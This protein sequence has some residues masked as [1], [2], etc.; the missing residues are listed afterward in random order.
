MQVRDVSHWINRGT[1]PVVALLAAFF[2]GLLF[3]SVFSRYVFDISIVQS[4][5]LTRIAFVWS[6]FLAASAVVGRDAHI[7]I[8]FFSDLLP[9]RAA[10]ILARLIHLMTLAF[11]LAM[12]WQGWLLV[13]KMATTTLPA[14]GISQVWLYGG[15]PVSGVLICLHAL[16]RVIDPL[17]PAEA[18]A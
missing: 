18:K 12:V 3:V 6:V 15:L 9:S 13:S 10:P 2:T 5:E 8:T 16:C 17:A 4:V 1:E 7:R 11:G 14:L